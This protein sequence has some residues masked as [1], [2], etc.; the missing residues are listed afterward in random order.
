[1]I[2]T[3]FISSIGKSELTQKRLREVF[4]KA[5]AMAIQAGRQAEELGRLEA[6]D[7]LGL[8]EPE[9]AETIS[10]LSQDA[11]DTVMQEPG[12]NQVTAHLETT[13]DA[14]DD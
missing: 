4:N 8:A 1:L 6:R 13:G 5:V 14:E 7:S 9:P 2:F 11:M 10:L 3:N 12:A